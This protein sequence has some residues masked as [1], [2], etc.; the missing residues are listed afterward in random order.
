[1]SLLHSLQHLCDDV[2]VMSLQQMLNLMHEEL[3][4]QGVPNEVACIFM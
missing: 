3:R 1:M 4:V 2:M